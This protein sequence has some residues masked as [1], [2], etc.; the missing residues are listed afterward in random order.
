VIEMEKKPPYEE[1]EQR[2]R[3]L[4]REKSAEK[5]LCSPEKD[6]ESMY[7]LIL[8][9]ISDT[10]IVT[11]DLGNM[12]YVCPNTAIIFGLSQDQVYKK[13]TIQRLMDGTVCDISEL[14]NKHAI[15]AIERSITT[16]CKETRCLLINAKSVSI[17][18]GTVL[19]VMH[20]ITDRKRAE[21]HLRKSEESYRTLT[22]NIPGMVY[23]AK[24]DWSIEIIAHSEKLCG[25]SADEF[26]NQKINWL[27]LI[28]PDDKNRF[29]DESSKIDNEPNS[30]YQEYRIVVKD[31]S[32]RWVSDQ[33]SSIFAEKRSLLCIDGI[34]ND[35]TEQRNISKK[36]EN[37][38]R[39]KEGLLGAGSLS[40]KMKRIT[41][42]T[43]DIL[44][45]DFARIWIVKEGDLCDSGCIHASVKEGPH[46][47]RHRN[48]CLHLVAS[49]GRYVHIDGAHRRVPFDCYKIGRVASGKE[50]GFL[51]NDVIHDLRVHNHD[52]A[53]EIGLVSFAGYR[54]LSEDGAPIGVL[55]LFSKKEIFPGDETLLQTITSTASEVVKFSKALELLQESEEKYRNIY[56]NAVEGFYQSI[57]EGRFV[58][59]NP[60]FVEMLGYDSPEDL[61]SNISDI[62]TQYYENP[63][64]RKR[65]ME[66]LEKQGMVENFEFQAKRK[67]GSK[68]WVSN[69]TRA[70]FDSEG[71]TVC[72]QGIVLDI[73]ERKQSEQEREKLISELQA[74]LSKIKTLKGLFPIC[75]YCKKIRDDKGYWNQLE[76][77]IQDHSEAEFSHGICQEC[78]KKYYP[79]MDI[80]DEDETQQ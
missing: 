45:A 28:H 34:I 10:I 60:A 15:K 46:V 74:A 19:Y 64:D 42:K 1:L 80:C 53:R 71:K 66:I 5:R 63:E 55:A 62:T 7:R 40:E 9:N 30:I 49:S 25:Y 2:I 39:L 70:N 3:D 54:L 6:Q 37:L 23:R 27:D 38:S 75:M 52:W 57:P 31:G 4:E 44:G 48:R 76:A 68:I 79:D 26:K 78:A 36:L 20:D 8:E 72:Y 11:D 73:T 77:Y 47:C 32:T 18:G 22:S 50:P 14:K 61:I 33:K 35:I 56:E 24:P 58:S 29:L 43:V 13:Q 41:D 59:V 67:D 16:S 69:S 65:F 21:E 12:L 51:T 17:N